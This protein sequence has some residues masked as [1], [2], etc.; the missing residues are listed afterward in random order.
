MK[1][2]FRNSKRPQTI[3]KNIIY[4]LK[5]NS[6]CSKRKLLLERLLSVTSKLNYFEFSEIDKA[7]LNIFILNKI[8]KKDNFTIIDI[9]CN[10]FSSDLAFKVNMILREIH[11]PNA[12]K[13]RLLK[14]L[15]LEIK[16]ESGRAFLDGLEKNE[17]FLN[18][19]KFC[20]IEL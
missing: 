16:T 17:D 5:N 10:D 2:F 8:S 18:I 15:N 12:K 7:I 19:L 14:L 11:S 6:I 20:E 9:N 1:K 3:I 13:E 4:E